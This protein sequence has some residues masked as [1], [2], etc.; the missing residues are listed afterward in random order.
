MNEDV[1]ETEVF[2]AETSIFQNS[3]DTTKTKKEIRKQRKNILKLAFANNPKRTK[4]KTT[5][6]SLGYGDAITWKGKKNI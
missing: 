1:D 4:F 5:A 2:A 3:I 6:E